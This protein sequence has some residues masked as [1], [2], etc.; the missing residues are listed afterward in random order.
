MGRGLEK[1]PYRIPSNA[2]NSAGRGGRRWAV[3]WAALPVDEESPPVF[4]THLVLTFREEGRGR[5]A[6]LVLPH[7]QWAK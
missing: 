4:G 7:T 5:S 1:T 2:C 3:V 6:L